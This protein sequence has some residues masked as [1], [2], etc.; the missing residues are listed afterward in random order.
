[1][2]FFGFVDDDICPRCGRKTTG[3]MAAIPDGTIC[4]E[5]CRPDY[6]NENSIKKKSKKNEL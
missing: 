6:S 5:Y 3:G 4:C 1:M 2:S